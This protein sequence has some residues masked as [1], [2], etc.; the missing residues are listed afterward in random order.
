MGAGPAHRS[1]L[2]VSGRQVRLPHASHL[3]AETRRRFAL[4]DSF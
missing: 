3:A 4:P 2:V 1:D